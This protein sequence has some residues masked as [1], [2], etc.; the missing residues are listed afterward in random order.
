MSEKITENTVV[1]F[2]RHLTIPSSRVLELPEY[3]ERK[4]EY[5]FNE[6]WAALEDRVRARHPE[7][8]AMLDNIEPQ[9]EKMW[10]QIWK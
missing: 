1:H 2:H 5:T 7:I 3:M 9:E 4:Y 10:W 8:F 6:P